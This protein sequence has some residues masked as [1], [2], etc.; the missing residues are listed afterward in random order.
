AGH[1]TLSLHDA[2]PI[3]L[4]RHRVRR[5]ELLEPLEIEPGV[6]EQRLI[7]LQLAF[8]LGQLR[9]ERARVDLGEQVSAADDLPLLEMDADQLAV[10]R[11]STRLNSSHVSI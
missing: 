9:L 11:K 2:L 7:A 8:E 3:L 6:V 10:D 5:D 1:Y 4:P